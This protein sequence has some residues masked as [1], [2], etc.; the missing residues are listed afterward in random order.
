MGRH[1]LC[2]GLLVLATTG[3]TRGWLQ[4]AVP[5]G[6]LPPKDDLVSGFFVAGFC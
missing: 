4:H 5:L 6:L 1:D 2:R 3:F